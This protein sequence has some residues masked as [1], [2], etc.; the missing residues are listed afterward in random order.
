[1]E[2]PAKTLFFVCAPIVAGSL[3]CCGALHFWRSGR[4]LRKRG[5]TTQATVAKKLRK[6]G[7]LENYYA[8]LTFVNLQGRQEELELKVRSRAW[9]MLR[10]GGIETITYLPDQPEKA[11]LGPKWGKQLLGWVFLFF[12][13]VGGS[14]AVTGLVLLIRL[15]AGKLQAANG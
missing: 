14:M 5:V 3:V 15:L 7:G 1:V 9:R 12:A 6:G 13:L 8:R 4:D 2:G 11:E 10:E